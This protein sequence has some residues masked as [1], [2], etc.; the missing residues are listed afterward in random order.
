MLSPETAMLAAAAEFLRASGIDV[1]VLSPADEALSDV[2]SLLPDV[3]I[4][5]DGLSDAELLRI[6]RNLRGNVG[7]QHVASLVM[8]AAPEHDE[9]NGKGPPRDSERRAGEELAG[10]VRQWLLTAESVRSGRDYVAHEGLAIDRRR[11]SATVDGQEIALTTTEFRI[12]WTLAQGAGRVFSPLNCTTPAVR[13]TRTFTSE[14]STFTFGRFARSSAAPAIWWKPSA[15]LAIGSRHR[16]PDFQRFS[17]RP[18]SDDRFAIMPF[19]RLVT[20]ATAAMTAPES[21]LA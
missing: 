19:G 14:P 13:T 3:V 9:S 11:F 21:P 2:R 6:C 17:T 15:A 8:V 18:A 16:T 1:H 4:A 7:S 12:L 20:P 10:A 5:T